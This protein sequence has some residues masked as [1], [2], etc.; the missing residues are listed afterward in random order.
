MSKSG[1][2]LKPWGLLNVWGE[3]AMPIGFFFTID[4]RAESA[5]QF[6]INAFAGNRR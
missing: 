2:I 6:R 5:G 4:G 3:F 1:M